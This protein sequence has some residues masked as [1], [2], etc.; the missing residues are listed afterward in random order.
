MADDGTRLKRCLDDSIYVAD[1]P[2][3]YGGCKFNARMTIVRMM[4]GS[5][6]LHSPSDIDAALKVEIDALGPVRFIVGP[7]NFHWLHLRKARALFP[8][9]ELHICPGIERKDPMLKFDWVLG[10][11]PPEAWAGEFDQALVR[12]TRFMW[13]VVFFHR[14]S[15]TLIVTDLL[16]NIGD[17]TPG[18]DL[19]LKFWWKVVYRMWNKVRPA[20]EYRMGWKDKGAAGASLAPILAW[21]FDQVIISHGGLI[22]ENANDVVREA[23][24]NLLTD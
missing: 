18:V 12:G 2:I 5:L 9:A 1:Y 21:D 10:D 7:G 3:R 20:P 14:P 23:W 13:E 15:R 24:S 6:W 11:R 19:A 17:S 4:D 8:D 16:E 22:T